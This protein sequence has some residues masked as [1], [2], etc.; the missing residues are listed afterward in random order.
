MSILEILS[1]IGTFI[2][3][4]NT[5]IYSISFSFKKE[6]Y[7]FFCVYL[8]IMLIITLLTTYYN[9][10]K[11]NNLFL[12]HYY[13]L[14]QFILLSLFYKYVF[15]NKKNKLLIN[16]TLILIIYFLVLQY[17]MDTTLFQI[18]NLTEVVVT[19]LPLIIY[20]IIFFYQNLNAKVKFIYI[21]IGVFMYLL[22][23]M[24]L[25]AS[26]NLMIELDPLI[27]KIVWIVNASLYIVFQILIFI[28]WRKNYYRK[29]PKS[30]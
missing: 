12:S 6:A 5:I 15:E 19:S 9:S 20:S 16:T 28:E 11:V 1:Y 13:F 22:C 4:I 18:F 25:F 26:G 24:L 8:L 30:S 21:N 7:S 17:A 29:I 14:S 2:L 10:Q 23:S 27:N 3:L